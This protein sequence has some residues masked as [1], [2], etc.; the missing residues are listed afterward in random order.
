MLDYFL[1]LY[2]SIIDFA[3]SPLFFRVIDD[4][5]NSISIFAVLPIIFT[6]VAFIKPIAKSFLF[7]LLDSDGKVET[8]RYL[9]F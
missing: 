5:A 3:L 1:F 7:F 4:A 2:V 8:V 6:V 9:P